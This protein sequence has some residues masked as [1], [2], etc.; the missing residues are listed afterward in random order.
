MPL[1]TRAIYSRYDSFAIYLIIPM[2]NLKFNK[3]TY[4]ISVQ[5]KKCKLTDFVTVVKEVFPL[6]QMSTLKISSYH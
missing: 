3:F 2:E 1:N 4:V 6:F 5:N